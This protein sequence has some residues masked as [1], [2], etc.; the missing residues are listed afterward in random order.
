[1]RG[2][3]VKAQKNRKV[4]ESISKAQAHEMER[5]LREAVPN[6]ALNAT[7]SKARKLT[8]ARIY[9]AHIIELSNDYYLAR[10]AEVDGTKVITV[11]RYLA[12]TRYIRSRCKTN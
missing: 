3:A 11:S 8:Q 2:T 4:M 9:K 12:L 10:L 5:I 6:Y 1:M 7:M